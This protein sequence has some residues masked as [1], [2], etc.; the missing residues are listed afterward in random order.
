[1]R[2]VSSCFR[3]ADGEVLAH[4]VDRETEIEFAGG[5]GLVAVLHLPG[6]R[7]TL[8]NGGNEF[9]D[10][11]V[12]LLREV[13]RFGEALDDA[14]DANRFAILASCPEPEVPIRFQARA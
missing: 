4:P 13:Q 2:A 7:G 5:H 10:V 6:L 3:K 12:G 1:M 8:G 11:E 9:L 14:G